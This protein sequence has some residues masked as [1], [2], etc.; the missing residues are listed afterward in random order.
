MLIWESRSVERAEIEALAARS[1]G[2]AECLLRDDGKGSVVL[3]ERGRAP[4]D[5]V[6]K[7]LEPV[8]ASGH[9]GPAAGPWVFCV[10]IWTPAEFREELCA[11]YLYEHGPIL[12]ECPQWRGFQCLEA[13]AARGNQLYVLHRLAT[14]TAL[15]S[16]QRKRSRD[17]PWFH[18]L[19]RHEWF[20]R[21]FERVLLRR[22]SLLWH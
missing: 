21:A 3:C 18:R 15:D 4:K 20:D 1:R 12:L 5:V 8:F 2:A 14:R 9:N 13:S 16:E 11:W 22:V 6:E 10:G 7:R 17:T 19:A